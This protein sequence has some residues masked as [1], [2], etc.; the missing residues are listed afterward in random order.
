MIYSDVSSTIPLE[1]DRFLH[2]YIL[3]DNLDI[4]DMRLLQDI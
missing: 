1:Y 3:F 2:I 4:P